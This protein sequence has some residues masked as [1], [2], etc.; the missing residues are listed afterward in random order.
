MKQF[1]QFIT[2]ARTTKASQEAMRLGLVG[3]GHGDWYDRQGNLKAKL[4]QGQYKQ[5]NLIQTLLTVK[6]KQ[7][8][9]MSVERTHLRLRLINLTKTM[10][11]ITYLLQ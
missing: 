8:Y 4:Q 9:R 10:S 5:Q 2:E 1:T 3:D 11:P 7:H 6:Q